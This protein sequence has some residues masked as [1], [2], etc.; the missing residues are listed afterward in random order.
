MWKNMHGGYNVA[1]GNRAGYW[2]NGSGNIFIG[3]SAAYH[4]T[5]SNR[6][7]IDNS[8]TANPLIFGEFDSNR[9]GINTSQPASTLHI[10]GDFEYDDN[11]Y[12]FFRFDSAEAVVPIGEPNTWYQV[13]S[14]SASLL[15]MEYSKN[16]TI[17][18]DTIIIGRSGIYSFNARVSYSGT[19]DELWQMGFRKVGGERS[20]IAERKTLSDDVIN[21]S[22]IWITE[23]AVNDKFLLEINNSTDTDDPVF[24]SILITIVKIDAD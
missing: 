3:D 12:G 17:S 1:I 4:Q 6:L 14:Q 7:V 24:R 22:C 16:I 10:G 13:T 23:V 18:N 8:P 20:G 9:I 21:S 2:N 5:G 11:A 15:T 19:N